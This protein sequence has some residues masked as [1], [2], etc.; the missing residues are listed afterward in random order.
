MNLRLVPAQSLSPFPFRGDLLRIETPD[1]SWLGRPRRERQLE[2]LT[3]WRFRLKLLLMFDHARQCKSKQ[4][5][6]QPA[7][8]DNPWPLC[9]LWGVLSCRII[10]RTGICRSEQKRALQHEKK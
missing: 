4:V 2:R 8:N 3:G 5:L 7:N 6:R 1:H 9:V 10:H